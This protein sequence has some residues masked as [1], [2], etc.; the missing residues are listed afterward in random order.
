MIPA[1][2]DAESNRIIDGIIGHR[3]D[4]IVLAKTA[5]DDNEEQVLE[6]INRK[7]RLQESF[8]ALDSFHKK[9]MWPQREGLSRITYSTQAPPGNAII[10]NPK[11]AEGGNDGLRDISNLW[12][13][14]VENMAVSN[15][16]ALEGKTRL[17][18]FRSLELRRERRRVPR[19]SRADNTG[20]NS[21]WKQLL[22]GQSGEWSTARELY[23]T[24]MKGSAPARNLPLS[25]IPFVQ[26]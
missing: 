11:K 14:F 25:T 3:I 9:W 17:P 5:S 24:K 16:E 22:L 19:L 7:Q 20:I 13:G 8:E 2:D 26:N 4:S 23:E 21:T 12:Q 1:E 18:I 15:D 6:L 10:Y